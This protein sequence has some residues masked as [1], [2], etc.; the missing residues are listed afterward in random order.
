MRSLTTHVSLP[1]SDTVVTVPRSKRENNGVDASSRYRVS[2]KHFEM[3]SASQCKRHGRWSKA[4]KRCR[5]TRPWLLSIC[6]HFGR[7]V[8]STFLT[9]AS[10]AESS[11]DNM[12][13]KCLKS[14]TLSIGLPPTLKAAGG[15]VAAACRG[16]CFRLQPS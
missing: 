12:R 16:L 5:G 1:W 2:L 3:V 15:S 11:P 9:H 4:S 10:G 7:A 8:L 13:P 6:R 14:E